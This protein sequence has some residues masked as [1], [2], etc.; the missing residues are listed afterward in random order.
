[1]ARAAVA[2]AA[3]TGRARELQARLVDEWRTWVM[4]LS[5]GRTRITIAER[6]GHVIQL[7]RPD[8]VIGAVER[9]V[10]AARAAS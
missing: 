8:L 10:S 6:S 9:L 4:A 2:R 1:V 7:D 3:A 5:P